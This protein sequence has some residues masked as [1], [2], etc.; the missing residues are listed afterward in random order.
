M[1]LFGS[2]KDSKAKAAPAKAAPVKAD[3]GKDAKG[4]KKDKKTDKQAQKEK[5]RLAAQ[6]VF[7]NAVDGSPLTKAEVRERIVCSKEAELFTIGKTKEGVSD[8]TLRY[9]Y[10]CQRGYYP[11]D[12]YKA[13]QDAYKISTQWPQD[14]QPQIFFGIFDGHGSEGDA[15]SYFVSRLPPPPPTCLPNA[16]LRMH[17]CT[18]ARTHAR[19]NAC[20]CS[21]VVRGTLA[22]P[23]RGLPAHCTHDHAERMHSCGRA[24]ARCVARTAARRRGDG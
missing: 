17:A 16:C 4:G 13:N 8:I 19:G 21:C 11:E 10:L 7:E 14:K 5:E 24:Q 9:A 2:K 1:P 6:A 12:L 23:A 15:C 18:H 20:T 3:K 22:R